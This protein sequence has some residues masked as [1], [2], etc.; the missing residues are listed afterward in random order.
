LE[1]LI[2]KIL[3]DQAALALPNKADKVKALVYQVATDILNENPESHT[4]ETKVA[5]SIAIRLKAEEVMIQKINDNVFWAAITSNQTIELIKEFKS[6]FPAEKEA[7]K[8]FE[9]VNLMTPE[10]IHLNSFMY[11]PILDLSAQHLKKLYGKLC[12]IK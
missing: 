9:Q 2:K 5:L 11:E 1:V 12:A 10:N 7:I 6:K 4:L 8:L 3:L